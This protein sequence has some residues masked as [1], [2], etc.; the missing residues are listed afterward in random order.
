MMEKIDIWRAAKQMLELY[1]EGAEMA[2]AQRAD[3]SYEQGDMF[4]F[5]LWRR[6]TNAVK[7]L[8]RQKPHVDE[9]LH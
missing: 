7:E 9:P 8:E 1:P 5:E 6:I 4:N 3:A 2:A